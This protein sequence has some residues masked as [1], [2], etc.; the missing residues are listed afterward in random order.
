MQKRRYG[1]TVIELLVVIAIIGALLALLLPAIQFARESA[2]KIHCTNNLKQVAVAMHAYGDINGGLLPYPGVWSGKYGFSWRTSLLPFLELSTVYDQIDFSLSSLDGKNVPAGRTRI[3]S[4]LCPNTPDNLRTADSDLEHATRLA[5]S[6]Y[7]PCTSVGFPAFGAPDHSPWALAGSLA[8]LPDEYAWYPNVDADRNTSEQRRQPRMSDISDGL[9]QTILV[10]EWTD[11]VTEI[12]GFSSARVMF[13]WMVALN[14]EDVGF[15]PESRV[16]SA[17]KARY[18]TIGGESPNPQGVVGGHES[19]GFV[20]MCDASVRWIPYTM[21]ITEIVPLF[22][23]SAADSF[24]LY[25]GIIEQ[26]SR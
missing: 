11:S 7:R 24:Q 8:T 5:T 21:R 20:A 2:R 19:G 23:R 15:N 4:Y 13:A 3:P 6:D 1:M 9:S 22:S 12:W 25:D 10:R 17:I 18:R 16:G 26:K 14:T